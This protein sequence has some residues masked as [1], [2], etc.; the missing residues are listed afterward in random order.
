MKN[1]Y[2]YFC[3]G[4]NDRL[5]VLS[6]DDLQSFLV[7][8]DD[9]FIEYR[10]SLNF[11]CSDTFGT[12]LEFEEADVEFIEQNLFNDWILKE[13]TT[14]R[15]GAEVNSPILHDDIELWSDLKKMCLFLSDNAVSGP[16]CASHIHLGIQ[17]LGSDIESWLNFIKLFSIY[18]N[19]IYRFSY[20]E[21]L[22]HRPAIKCYALPVA[23]RFYEIYS[24]VKSNNCDIET[25]IYELKYMRQQAVNFSNVDVNNIGKF[26]VKNTI[27]FRLSNGTFDHVIWQNYIVLFFSLIK[28]S[29]SDKFDHD[30]LDKRYRFVSDKMSNLLFYN[31]I[32]IEQAL[33][34][35]DIIFNNN[36]DK[37]YF[38]RQYFKSFQ[39]SSLFVKA[40]KF[41]KKG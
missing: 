11:S 28:Y 1:V 19:I 7:L 31:E 8:L 32:Y 29:V 3:L 38:L 39:V 40:K 6:G 13:E 36:L 25:L 14:V 16:N 15:N 30:I 35:A 4:D 24:F 23:K 20:G 17:S 27:E 21:Y 12:E 2:D 34:F 26:G 37:L 41:T 22:S 5:S 33:E 18:E 10:D 9:I